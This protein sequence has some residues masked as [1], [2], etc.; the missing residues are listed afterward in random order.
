[1]QEF[2][3]QALQWYELSEHLLVQTVVGDGDD[4]Y[5]S[6]FKGNNVCSCVCVCVRLS[7]LFIQKSCC[8]A[9]LPVFS[10]CNLAF[11][12][13]LEELNFCLLYS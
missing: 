3:F 11:G 8:I 4:V 9:L 10:V 6:C 5:F 13:C 7:V 2:S 1:M 12:C